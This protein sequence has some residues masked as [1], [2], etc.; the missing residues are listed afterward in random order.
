MWQ[1]ILKADFKTVN[2]PDS[3]FA[4]FYSAETDTIVI[5]VGA[6]SKVMRER[7]GRNWAEIDV[8]EEWY[9]EKLIGLIKHESIHEAI[10]KA[11]LTDA[12][13]EKFTIDDDILDMMK[14]TIYRHFFHELYT[15]VLDGQ[16]WI[17][18][19][20]KAAEYF[21]RH[22]ETLAREMA[23]NL[24]EHP[25]GVE[26]LRM[27]AD[28]LKK[29]KQAAEE[30][31]I[32]IAKWMALY[33]RMLLTKLEKELEEELEANGELSEEFRERSRQGLER[34]KDFRDIE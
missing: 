18:A 16:N 24:V 2:D 5:N 27:F 19:L 4:G 28:E 8:I 1:I 23:E 12:I 10:E 31:A 33:Q 34:V 17:H 3:E 20:N 13:K 7:F 32:G 25:H 21:D 26:M 30:M 11:G 14:I 9:I 6:V 29:M 22:F 15:E